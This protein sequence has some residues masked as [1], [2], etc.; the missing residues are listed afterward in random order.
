MRIINCGS[1]NLTHSV[2]AASISGDTGVIH[3]VER[4]EDLQWVLTDGP[5]PPYMVLLES[6]LFTR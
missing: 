4:E 1:F 2:L 3:V 6:K 5:N